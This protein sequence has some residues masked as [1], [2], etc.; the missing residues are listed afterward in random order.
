MLSQLPSMRAQAM[1][2]SI[3]NGGASARGAL[4]DRQYVRVHRRVPKGVKL[5]FDASYLTRVKD[6][7][8]PC[9][10]NLDE[11]ANNYSVISYGR[12]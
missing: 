2:L 12:A 11:V 9:N 6:E 7:A 10:R 4:I 5:F 8:Q 1:A 3:V